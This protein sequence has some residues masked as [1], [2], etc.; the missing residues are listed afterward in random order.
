MTITSFP[1]VFPTSDE[2]R[3]W[4]VLMEGKVV[5]HQTES[6]A[7]SY[8]GPHGGRPLKA[9][10]AFEISPARCL[11]N[12]PNTPGYPVTFGTVVSLAVQDWRVSRVKVR[13]ALRALDNHWRSSRLVVNAP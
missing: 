4:V 3:L 1:Y 8:A 12:S 2:V 9:K 13:C 7:G 10:G 6:A 5:Y 11:K